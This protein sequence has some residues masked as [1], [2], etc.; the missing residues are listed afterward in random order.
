MSDAHQFLGAVAVVSTL[1]LLIV[2]A[3]AA[4]T[5]RRSAGVI[6]HRFAVDRLVLLV[7]AI[8]A[9]NGVIGL[10]LLA[11]AGRRPA[12]DLHLVYG[13]AALLSLPV[14]VVLGRRGPP[15]NARAWGRRIGWIIVATVLLLGVELRLFMTG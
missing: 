5:A 10:M 2:A 12:D 4:A 15:T 3:A 8:I 1:A 13:P 7:L 11:A 9:V 14:G 6:D